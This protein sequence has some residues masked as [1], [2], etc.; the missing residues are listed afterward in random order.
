MT[1]YDFREGLEKEKLV[2]VN[3]SWDIVSKLKWVGYLLF[4][5]S[6]VAVWFALFQFAFIY[7]PLTSVWIYGFVWLTFV[8]ISAAII[9]GNLIR[10]Y[11]KKLR[12]KREIEMN[13]NVNENNHEVALT[14][15]EEREKNIA[16]IN[17]VHVDSNL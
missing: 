13:L 8:L 15:S 9:T 2:F 6:I 12:K 16:S 1:K 10:N 4:T 7:H 5:W 17:Y 14:N 11:Q 3:K